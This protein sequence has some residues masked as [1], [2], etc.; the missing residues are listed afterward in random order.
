MQQPTKD[1]VEEAAIVFLRRSGA[2]FTP[3]DNDLMP[4]DC[5]VTPFD[6]SQSK[7]EGVSHTYKGMDGYAPMAA[8]L[9]QEGY[10]LELELRAGSQ[11]CQKGTPQFLQ[12]VIGR[13]RQLT[14]APLAAAS[15]RRERCHREHRRGRGQQRARGKGSPGP[16]RDQVE[17]APGKP[18]ALARLCRGHTAIGASRVRVSA[19]PCST[20]SKR[21]P[22]TATSTPCGASCA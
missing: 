14:A 15:G 10:C 8:Y 5:D 22:T 18:R 11:H 21:A 9:G 1:A 12:R 7:K 6:N 16:V 19:S 13:A 2:R 3:L 4:L 20:S 17:P